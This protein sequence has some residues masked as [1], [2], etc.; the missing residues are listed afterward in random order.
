MREQSRKV[1]R[2]GKAGLRFLLVIM[3]VLLSGWR[4]EYNYG[5]LP[6]VSPDA[7]P[8][9]P[10]GEGSGE[11]PGVSVIVPARNEQSNLPRLLDSLTT[12]DYPHYEI[13]VVDDASTD[14]TAACARHY[15]ACGVR[16]I[17]SAGPSDG[18]TGKNHACW[19]GADQSQY[20]WLLFIDA[21]VT[22]EPWAIRSV[23][24]FAIEQHTGA[25]SLFTVPGS[26]WIIDRVATVWDLVLVTPPAVANEEAERQRYTL[27]RLLRLLKKDPGQVCIALMPEG[28]EGGTSGLIEAVPGSGRALYALSAKGLPI[29]PAAVSEVEG[30]FRVQFGEPFSLKDIPEGLNHEQLDAWARDTVMSRIAELL[31]A[32]LRGRF[33]RQLD[34]TLG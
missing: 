27:L 2:N 28:D 12:Q 4:A 13:I 11:W 32:R 16:L 24:A 26:R 8:E 21:D 22:L 29:L 31:P 6:E 33:G 25:L 20:P 5:A 18:W 9:P 15:A 23:I 19:L 10:S 30:H 3:G 17:E 7:S 1:G 34:G 14:D